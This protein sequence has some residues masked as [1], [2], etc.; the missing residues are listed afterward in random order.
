MFRFSLAEVIYQDS[1]PFSLQN[2]TILSLEIATSLMSHLL[3]SKTMGIFELSGNVIF[4]RR[5]LSHL[6][7]DRNVAAREISKTKAAATLK[8]IF[9]KI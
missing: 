2:L 3:A 4:S 6:L 9:F 7:T 1:I 8:I 5:S